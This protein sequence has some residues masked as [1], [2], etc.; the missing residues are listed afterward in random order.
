[1]ISCLPSLGLAA[2][3]FFQAFVGGFSA[4]ALME[5]RDKPA[6]AAQSPVQPLHPSSPNKSVPSRRCLFCWWGGEKIG[7]RGAGPPRML[8]HGIG[9]FRKAISMSKCELWI[10]WRHEDV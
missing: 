7:R 4:V 9:A 2:F 8:V 5:A 3:A 6:G 1:M 10:T